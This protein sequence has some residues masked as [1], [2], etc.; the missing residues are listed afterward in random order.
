MKKKK[1]L[2]SQLRK[3]VADD[4]QYWKTAKHLSLDKIKSSK[5][6]CFSGRGKII[7]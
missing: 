1:R 4:E 2:L 3:N 5:I 6:G 7:R